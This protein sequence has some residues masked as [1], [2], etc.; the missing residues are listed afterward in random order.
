MFSDGLRL[1]RKGG[2]VK[3]AGQWFKSE[4]LL[5]YVGKQ[6]AICNLEYWL[7]EADAHDAK[8]GT[9]IATIKPE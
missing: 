4:K 8:Y 9:F 2:R 3:A 7:S 5:P 1:V 6:V